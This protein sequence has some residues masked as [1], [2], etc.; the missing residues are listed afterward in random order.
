MP[1]Y[2]SSVVTEIIQTHIANSGRGASA[3]LAEAM[4]V[5]PQTVSKWL[6]G[7]TTPGPERW[8]D[9]EHA[10]GLEPGTVAEETGYGDAGGVVLRERVTMLEQQVAE[11]LDLVRRLEPPG[12]LE[13]AG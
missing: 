12:K 1:S 13:D 8:E 6:A 4:K 9:L 11:L 5:T 10:L 7:Q 2:N 3:R